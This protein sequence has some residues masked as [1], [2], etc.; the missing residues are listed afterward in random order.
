[1]IQQNIILLFSQPESSFKQHQTQADQRECV[2]ILNSLEDQ[3]LN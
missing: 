3:L 2:E 1:M